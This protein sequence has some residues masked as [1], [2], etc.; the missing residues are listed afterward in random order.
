M[1]LPLIDLQ[2]TAFVQKR[3]TAAGSPA[4]VKF[5]QILFRARQITKTSLELFRSHFDDRRQ[6]G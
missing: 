6:L 1:G 5:N 2:K 4:A 3:M